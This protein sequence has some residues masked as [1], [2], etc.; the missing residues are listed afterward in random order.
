MALAF[1]VL[2]AAGLLALLLVFGQKLMRGWFHIIARGKSQELFMLNLL[3]VALG[4]AW[5]TEE[6]GLS[7][8][9]GAFLAG[10]LISETEY[11]H[12]VEEDI[13]P[14]RDV[15]LGLFFITI[16][17]QLDFGVVL[18]RWWLV[19]LLASLPVLLKFAVVLLIGRIFGQSSGTA[20]RSALALAT[21]GEFGLVLLSLTERLEL[22]SPNLTQPILAAMLLS[23]I[24]TPFIVAASDRIVLRFAASEW[25]L[26]SLNLTQIA[27][28]SIAT[29]RPVVI[30]GFGRSGQNLARL[31]RREG[32]DYVALDL[33]PDRV[34]EAAAAGESVV[35]GDAGR[36]ESLIAAGL[37]RASAV[38]ITYA[39]T[40]SALKVL[41]HI[42]HLAPQLPVIVRTH[43]DS[44]LEV[45][46]AAGATEVVPEIVEGSLMLASHALVLLG[47]PLRRVVSRV[48]EMRDSR[49][50]LLR[51]YFHGADD[52]DGA[53]HDAVRLH[54]LV[55]DAGAASVGKKLD[56]MGLELMGVHV[57]AINRAGGTTATQSA[58][59][60]QVL[61][62]GDVL[63][64]RGTPE[65]LALAEER[66]L[67]G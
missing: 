57:S 34:R 1:A 37:A 44:D 15:L 63:V 36:K 60:S 39:Q 3:L 64:L 40:P 67:K 56:E 20:L 5:I 47:V 25:L 45:L 24:A 16:G 23:M 32:I 9:L 11:R 17:M 27:A 30:C 21:A 41:H 33:D 58:P 42:R 38:V 28:R 14:F 51:G 43:D 26:A 6:A 35:F 55:L 29:D 49:Y 66:L 7:L 54:S 19:L 52:P 8:A 22:V 59:E 50:A 65:T 18:A 48:Q 53:A 61:A 4:L 62:A 31:L 46:R 13:K 2:K 10:M 12:Q